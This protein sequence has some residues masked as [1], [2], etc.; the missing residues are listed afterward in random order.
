ML[1]MSASVL[2][3]ALRADIIQPIKPSKKRAHHKKTGAA[4]EKQS[5]LIDVTFWAKKSRVDQE[6]ETCRHDSGEK[7]ASGTAEN[8]PT[9]AYTEGE[10]KL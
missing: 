2:P 10:Q 9:Q 6:Q 3:V 4:I 5:P 8:T 7:Q 1:S